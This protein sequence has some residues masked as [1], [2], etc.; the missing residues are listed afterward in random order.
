MDSEELYTKLKT[1]FPL[2][3]DLMRHLD[4]N[5]CWEYIITEKSTYE[6]EQKLHFYLL[7]KNDGNLE[8][9][10][11]PISNPDL[12][13]FFTEKAILNLIQGN[14]TADMYY[15]RY[16]ELMKNPHKE[17]EIDSKINKPRLKLLKLGYRAWQRDFKF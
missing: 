15:T 16:R 11:N 8:I 2:N 4:N 10:D 3:I 6:K 1:Y 9:L 12:I 17:I 5:A 13:L 14:P 7:K